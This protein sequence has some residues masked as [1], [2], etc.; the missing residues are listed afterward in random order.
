MSFVGFCFVY[1]YVYTYIIYSSFIYLFLSL[2]PGCTILLDSGGGDCLVWLEC[3]WRAERVSKMSVASLSVKHQNM[4]VAVG[5]MKAKGCQKACKPS[6][7]AALLLPVLGSCVVSWKLKSSIWL[8]LWRCFPC[9][10][11]FMMFCSFLKSWNCNQLFPGKGLKSCCV[12]NHSVVAE[13]C[14]NPLLLPYYC[15]VHTTV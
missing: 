13:V 1:M 4:P 6:E 14:W 9:Q 2:Y 11:P 3:T 7:W 10:G 5:V 15:I 8:V 12:G